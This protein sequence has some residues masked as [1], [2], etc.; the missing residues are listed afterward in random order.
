M[1]K[2]QRYKMDRKIK[3]R[4]KL[5]RAT[6]LVSPSTPDQNFS[7]TNVRDWWF[8]TVAKWDIEN[9]RGRQLQAVLCR[10]YMWW[11]KDL[12]RKKWSMQYLLAA[13]KAAMMPVAYK[14]FELK[15]SSN[16]EESKSN[17]GLIRINRGTT[18]NTARFLVCRYCFLQNLILAPHWKR[19]CVL[20]DESN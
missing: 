16:D 17:W 3:H 6:K 10:P 13:W 7:R 11:K 15:V 20:N 2:S 9:I 1:C 4:S 8:L 12:W 14:G 18:N 19:Q 5:L